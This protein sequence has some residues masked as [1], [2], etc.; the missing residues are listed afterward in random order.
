[1]QHGLDLVRAAE[2]IGHTVGGVGPFF[3]QANQLW[4][5]REE[6]FLVTETN[7]QSIGGQSFN[8]PPYP[9]QLKQAA[10]GLIARG[11]RMVEYWHW[12]TLGYG[13]ETYWGG[14]LPHS[15]L[16]GRIYEEVSEIGRSLKR[17]GPQLIGFRP[18]ADVTMVYSTASK[19]SFEFIAPLASGSR[20]GDPKSYERIF[21]AFHSGIIESNRQA[22]IVQDVRLLDHDPRSF[23]STNPILIA[24]A[25]YITSDEH[26]EWMNTYAES[27]GHLVLGIRSAYADEEA[28]ARTAV[29]PPGLAG[30]ARVHYEEFSNLVHEIGVRS[31]GHMRISVGAAATEWMD[32]L[33]T[34]GAEV[35]AAYDDH[36]LGR[37]SAI[38][39]TTR[40]LGRITYIGAFPN[41]V[42]SRDISR[43]L[44]PEPLSAQWVTD[45]E[46]PVLVQSGTTSHGRVWFVSNWS[47]A[48]ARVTVP[49]ACSDLE[50]GE[51]LAKGGVV[52]IRARGVR[53]FA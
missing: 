38:T 10:Y 24:P 23:A 13:Y 49:V 2:P 5:I 32:G 53:I 39:T 51:A 11:A 29:A 7:A 8:L 30:P 21:D 45:P 12:Q 42:L 15:G 27:G 48:D 14:V 16:P 1:M 20:D 18:D 46:S 26:L 19:W 40:G 37:F 17:V 9:G 50:S 41:R 44:A 31:I 22:V 28:R 3:R 36:E 52:T 34:D 47:G 6:R 33:I 25:F 35:L 4:S 43:W